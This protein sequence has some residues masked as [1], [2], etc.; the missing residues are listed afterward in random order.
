MRATGTDSKQAWSRFSRRRFVARDLGVRV[1]L[2]GA[3]LD[4]DHLAAMAGASA[5]ALG[6]MRALEA[7]AVANADEGRAVGH[8][9][10]RAPE[11]APGRDVAAAI[12][13]ALRELGSLVRAVHAG[14]VRGESGPFAHLVHVGIGGSAL[15]AQM[16]CAATSTHDDRLAVHF[17]D[18]AD[19]DA[20]VSLLRQL[21]GELG[22]TLVSVV[23][24]SG[25]TPTPLHVASVLEEAYARAGLRFARHAIA[26]TVPGSPLDR[27]ATTE[28]WPARLPIWDWVG[29]RTSITSAVGLLPAALQGADVGAFLAGAAAMDVH[30]RA[31][32]LAANPAMLLAL[33]W[34]RLTRGRAE[35]AMVVLPYRDRLALLPRYVQQLAMESLGKRRDRA[36]NEV[37]QGLTV[38][39]NKGTTDQH[40]YLQQLREGP[41]DAFVTF[42]GV[43]ADQTAPAAALAVGE[44]ATL[45][46]YLFASLEGTRAALAADGRHHIS[47]Q[48]ADAAPRSL[49]ALV[50]LFERAVG[51]YAELVD[52]NA[53]HQPSVDKH[54]AADLLAIQA[55]ALECLKR[56]GRPLG[57]VE[58]AQ[59]IGRPERAPSVFLVLERLAALPDRRVAATGGEPDAVRFAHPGRPAAPA[60]APATADSLV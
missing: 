24:K 49:G 60:P 14:D 29:G 22:R 30:T 48:L 43:D 45:G 9:W 54:A 4:D 10:L 26:T 42:V 50:A 13:D 44:G 27:R 34:H 3:G 6:A 21:G 25:V 11:L 15:G 51:L 12:E 1:D 7:G 38:Y 36:G 47:I 35:R 5:A 16:L 20:V 59:A 33:A 53:Y 52:V 31:A 8:Y 40:A 55:G 56:A 19:P 18:N 28:D 23:S 57:A 41:D 39:G 37:R 17:L 32:D 58:I 46:D 2:S